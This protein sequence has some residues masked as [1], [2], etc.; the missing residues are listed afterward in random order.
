MQ[1]ASRGPSNQRGEPSRRGSRLIAKDVGRTRVTRTR[2][3]RVTVRGG[4]MRLLASAVAGAL[5]GAVI[6][7][8]W[9]AS[10]LKPDDLWALF[11]LAG[12]PFV[13][14]FIGLFLGGACGWLWLVVAVG[15]ESRE[16]DRVA[17]N[18]PQEPASRDSDNR[19]S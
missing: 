17:P 12:S 8:S 14:A 3:G 15:R 7:L 9:T 16:G 2:S 10:T 11:T 1:A 4:L 13:G 18:S 19:E 6:W 5:A